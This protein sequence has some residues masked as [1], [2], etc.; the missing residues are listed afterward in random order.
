MKV[1]LTHDNSD[2]DAVAAMLAAHKLNPDARPVLPTRLNRNVTDFMTLYQSGLPFVQQR[3]FRAENIER[4]ILVDTQRLPKIHGLKA[5]VD[6]HII[7]HHPLKINLQSNQTFTGDTTGA[8]TTLL[9]EELSEKEISLTA[10]EATLLALGI[11]EDTG[12]LTYGTT[13]PRDIEA[14]AWLLKQGAVLDTVREYLSPALNDQQKALLEKLLAATESRNIDGHTIVIA[15]A[16]VDEH[17][18]EISSVAHRLRDMLDSTAL[19]VLVQMPSNL[20]LVARATNDAID[21]SEIARVFGGGGHNRAA[22]AT[23]YDKTIDETQTLLWDIVTQKIQP[24]ILIRDL[25]SPD[26]Q[27]VEANQTVIDVIGRLRRIGH[28][29]YPVIDDNQI[30]GLLT[31]RD[32]DRAIEHD[33]G[34]LSIREIMRG[35]NVWLRP[36][37]TISELEHTMVESRWGQ[38]PVV[39]TENRIIGIVTRT[40]LINYWA[41]SHPKMAP[42]RQNISVDQ[43]QNVLGR[44]VLALIQIIADFA[45]D[46]NLSVYMV[47]GSVRDLLL[48]KP[49]QDIDFVV[50]QRA[51]DL[52]NRLQKHFGGEVHSYQPF[53]TAKWKIDEE[54]TIKIGI[55]D[56]DLP[57]HIDFATARNEFYEHPTALPTVYNSSIKLDLHRRDFTINTL[58]IQISPKSSMWRILDFYGGLQDVAD[59]VIRVLHSLSFVDD[60]TRILRAVRFEH[61]LGFTID[62]RTLELMQSSLPMLRRITG[63]RLRNELNLLLQENNPAEGLNLLQQRGILEAI[64]P[65]FVI[66]PIGLEHIR[67]LPQHLNRITAYLPDGVE[68][69]TTDFYWHII[70]MDIPIEDLPELCERL[71]FGKQ[72]TRSMIDAAQLAQNARILYS[73]ETVPSQI[74][75]LLSRFSPTAIVI[76]MHYID[77]TIAK[78]NLRQYLAEWQY[79]KPMTNGYKLKQMG[80][81]PGPCY[82][83][84][85]NRLRAA[86]LDG[87]VQTDEEEEKLLDS[88]ISKER[89]CDERS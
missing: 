69:T 28:E 26:P 19:F 77:D 59:G 32:A 75:S 74:V 85:L 48:D 38:I 65:A 47:G 21:V 4:V 6:I 37:D 80:L 73:A 61:R 71:I 43:V 79:V 78:S 49:N 30:V 53:G 83:N 14:A 2:F 88:L 13:T 8:V 87:I 3:D 22:A 76:A 72:A 57:D 60:P 18:S 39:D 16:T 68:M 41:R 29:G 40:D 44:G 52:V 5:N 17:I 45:N 31:L 35:G 23:I 51:I 81:P 34:H 50:E 33:L 1:I 25:M 36:D 54:V 82:G 12:S 7:D 27:V 24:D 15:K 46:E 67:Q 55:V 20:L 62:E 58:A 63:E 89:I 66:S 84:I 42:I 70:A 56:D 9:T 10:L 11:Y 64:H 86:R